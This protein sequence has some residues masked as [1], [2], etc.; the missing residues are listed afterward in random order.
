MRSHSE[1]GPFLRPV[2]VTITVPY[3]AY[4]ALVERSNVQ[5][6]SLSNLAAYLLESALQGG[7]AGEHNPGRMESA[8]GFRRRA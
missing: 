4:Q 6:R 3:N 8:D 1:P 2:R 7:Q 5:G